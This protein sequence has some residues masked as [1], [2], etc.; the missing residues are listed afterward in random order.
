MD[1]ILASCTNGVAKPFNPCI[2]Y[3]HPNPMP[4]PKQ[5]IE[6]LIMASRLKQMNPN[7]AW[8]L[9]VRG[10]IKGAEQAGY[11]LKRQPGR[12]LS[13]TYEATKNGETKILS[14]R[15][16][17]DRW[18][19]FPP[20]ENGTRW[21]T[22]DDVD[23]VLVS[24]V[25]DRENPQSIDV[26]IFPADEVRNRFNAS[27]AAR[28]SNGHTVR[29]N[30]GMWIMLDKDNNKMASHVGNGLAADYPAIAHFTIDSLEADEN[31]I[32]HEDKIVNTEIIF[33]DKNTTEYNFRTISDILTFARMK[34]AEIS[35]LPTDS[36][37]LE[38]KLGL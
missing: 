29:D 2:L 12:G 8:H 4:F 26:Y 23:L 32:I 10:A 5:I 30:Y 38:L 20:L 9:M 28:I 22:L 33:N 14:I 15:T 3:R 6:A 1:L 27:Y 18:I 16:T 13:N 24:A 17:Q 25:N 34:I 31:N 36:V 37:S 11:S 35:G 7:T 19:A 21:K